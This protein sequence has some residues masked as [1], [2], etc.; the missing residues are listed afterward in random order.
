MRTP[1]DA[2]G[3]A[4]A[5]A[6]NQVTPPKIVHFEE[7]PYPPEAEKLG[8]EANVILQLD[9]DKDG[10]VTK[11]TAKEPAGHGFD[12]AAIAAA[13]KFTFEPARKGDTPIAARILY[14]YGFTLKPAVPEDT[15][16]QPSVPAAP[17]ESLRGTVLSIE[18]DVPLAGASVDLEKGG[19]HRIVSTGADGSWSFAGLEP[20]H[21][22][23]TVTSSGF[24]PSTTE[25]DL[26]AGKVTELQYRL[27]IDEGGIEITVQGQRPPR[28][29]T[30]RTVEQREISRIP[31]TNGDA[32]R[33]LQTLPGVARPPGL[34]GLLIV[35]G[36]SPQDTQTFVD[37]IYV[38]L[39][40]HFGGLS[41]V[42]PTEMLEK[43]DFY[44]GNFSAQYGR[45]MGGVVEVGV[46]SPN[47]DGKYHGLA[48]FDLIDGRVMAEGPIPFLKGW[49]FLV[50]GRRSWV[51][52]WLKPLLT[53]LDA[54]VTT[55]PV[56]YDY[57]AFIE[58]KPTSRSQFRIG[59]YGS[60][61]RFEVL[62]RDP[63]QQDPAFG[64]NLA[65]K[66][67]FYRIQARYKND[68]SDDLKFSTVLSYGLDRFDF[69]L[70]TFFFKVR[71]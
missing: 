2:P 8:L 64:G 15:T 54:G 58:T 56:Y 20:G 5:P 22:K 69:G 1:Q 36:S 6:P 31:G 10:K 45:L 61:D 43:I 13:M 41:S 42:I 34:A 30:R 63:A 38:P 44:P 19:E 23:I 29:V 51:D 28:E 48:Q 17:K 62:I 40:Y 60:E 50:G 4:P 53:E 26:V 33:A 59:M 24:K 68:I 21:Y 66:T 25:E 49:S 14:R 67:G 55:A 65:L 52:A 71:N 70:G 11:A 12:E 16:G 7:S 57:Q 9:I 3:D 27:S 18:G 32:L 39:I 37:G 47:K 46:R 35:R